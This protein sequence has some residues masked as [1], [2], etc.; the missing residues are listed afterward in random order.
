MFVKLFVSIDFVVHAYI[1]IV[2]WFKFFMLVNRIS[3][4][5]SNPLGA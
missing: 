2:Q 3:L 5:I 4:N 1:I